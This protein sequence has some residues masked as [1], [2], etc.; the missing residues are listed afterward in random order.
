MA[1]YVEASTMSF[2]NFVDS[3]GDEWQAFD[4]V[5]HAEERRNY[6]RRLSD[7]VDEEDAPER[8]DADRRL[9]VGRASGIAG[10]E[11]WLCFERGE[12]RRRLSPIPRDWFRAS[13]AELEEYRLAAR[14][15][16]P[17]AVTRAG[18][19]ESNA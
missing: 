10:A 6:D 18:A 3:A 7:P 8:R 11:G 5:P 17:N 19:G 12:Q 2:R 4:V 9:T 13:D 14:P 1:F 16:R 15:V